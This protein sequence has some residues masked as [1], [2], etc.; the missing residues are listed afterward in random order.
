MKATLTFDSALQIIL[1]QLNRMT[2]SYKAPN[3]LK[4]IKS[5]TDCEDG[6]IT[7]ETNYGEEYAD[8]SELLDTTPFNKKFVNNYKSALENLTQKD[9][10]LRS[11]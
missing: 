1:L 8:F 7:M 11:E 9:I 4:F 2:I 5:I 3:K 10:I 6:F